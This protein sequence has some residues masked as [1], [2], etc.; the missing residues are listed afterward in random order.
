MQGDEV[1]WV[2]SK[3]G[4]GKNEDWKTPLIR[5]TVSGIGCP[6]CTGK[7]V[8]KGKNDMNTTHPE[9]AKQWDEEKNLKENGRTKYDTSHGWKD[10]IWWICEKGHSYDASPNDRTNKG[11]GCRYCS[12]RG[13]LKGFNDLETYCNN[14]ENQIKYKIKNK[15][16]NKELL[17]ILD[18]WHEDNEIS[19][20]DIICSDNKEL[21]LWKCPICGDKYRLT[22]KRK[23]SREG[24]GCNQCVQ[25]QN[26][27]D[28]RIKKTK[29]KELSTLNPELAKEWHPDPNKNYSVKYGF[30][31]THNNTSANSKDKVWWKCSICGHEWS[32]QVYTRN[33][34]S[35]CP[36]CYRNRNTKTKSVK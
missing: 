27:L 26:A 15:K 22:V 11:T 23:L 14:K 18:E 29:G 25:K 6:V 21:I 9:I 2:C 8:V 36:E 5:R 24:I 19:P 17:S 32:T 10:K 31:L 12:N 20:K 7:I 4:Y 30:V 35:G 34:G 16:F 13:L 28:L 3:C 33:K 1:A